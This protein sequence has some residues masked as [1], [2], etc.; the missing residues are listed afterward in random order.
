[1]ESQA[2][3]KDSI[4]G[5]AGRLFSLAKAIGDSFAVTYGEESV[6][7]GGVRG[8]VTASGFAEP[9]TGLCQLDGELGL[10]IFLS[11]Q[12]WSRMFGSSVNLNVETEGDRTVI[13]LTARSGR[14]GQFAGWS[15]SPLVTQEIAVFDPEGVSY[16]TKSFQGEPRIAS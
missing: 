15:S 1:M 11:V 3:E 13:T 2:V 10:P 14:V 8:T 9:F 7:D 16:R 6:R 12:S 4:I 5:K